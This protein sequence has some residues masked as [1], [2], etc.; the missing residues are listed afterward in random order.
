M[1]SDM[2]KHPETVE[3][4]MDMALIVMFE[5]ENATAHSARHF[6]EGFAE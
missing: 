4:I 6:I 2:R 5:M 1:L 3:L